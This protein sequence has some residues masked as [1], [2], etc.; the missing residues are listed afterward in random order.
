MNV[1]RY[2]E[3]YFKIL[4]ICSKLSYPVP[5]KMFLKTIHSYFYL[6]A[7]ISGLIFSATFVRDNLTDH[8]R[9]T[10]ALLIVSAAITCL[11]S[12]ISTSMSIDSIHRVHNELQT[13]VNEG[14]IIILKL[15]KKEVMWILDLQPKEVQPLNS[16]E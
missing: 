10:N 14:R 3:K 5:E 15:I 8:V 9:Y 1:L 4:G 7:A 16:I 13:L 6:Y 12:Y 11:G 2:C